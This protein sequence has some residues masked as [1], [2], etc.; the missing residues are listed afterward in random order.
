MPFEEAVRA[1]RALQNAYRPGLQAVKGQ[2]RDRVECD[3][4]RRLAGSVDLDSSLATSL[5]N[6]PR[7]D[8][9]IGV[10]TPQNE[11]RVHWVEVH[12]AADGD[13]NAVLKK[14]AWLRSWLRECAP[15][16]LAITASERG[17]VWIASGD[18]GIRPGSPKARRL[19]ARGISFPCR[20]FKIP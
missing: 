20:R 1:V 3:D 4:T 18:I 12:P 11:D 16:L 15:G 10:T 13:V 2:Y 5:P 8:Y 19:A 7:W 17:Y 14:H 6:E 9:G